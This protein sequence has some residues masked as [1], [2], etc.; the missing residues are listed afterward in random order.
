M[1]HTTGTIAMIGTSTL[2][3]RVGKAL[4]GIEQTLV[5]AIQEQAALVAKLEE[6]NAALTQVT[7]AV[8]QSTAE[9]KDASATQLAAILGFYGYTWVAQAAVD[10]QTDQWKRQARETEAKKQRSD[11]ADFLLRV[12]CIRCDDG[13]AAAAPHVFC[14]LVWAVAHAAPQALWLRHALV[15]LPLWAR[16]GA[17]ALWQGLPLVRHAATPRAA[18]PPFA[19]AAPQAAAGRSPATAAARCVYGVVLP[20]PPPVLLVWAPP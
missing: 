17:P 19:V 11:M 10:P 12:L 13:G 3:S 1:R 5:Q 15:V 14:A 2:D 16:R 4:S 20:P 18:A 6:V 8:M 9:V 7:Q